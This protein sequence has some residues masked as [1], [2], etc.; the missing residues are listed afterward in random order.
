MPRRC[1]GAPTP[2]IFDVAVR[3]SAEIASR[4]FELYERR[5]SLDGWDLDDWPDAD[6]EML[7]DRTRPDV[8][9][10]R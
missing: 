5:C 8:T 6:G 1:A 7:Q 9:S 3:S 2:A 10:R 4:A